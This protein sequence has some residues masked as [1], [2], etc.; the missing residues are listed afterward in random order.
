MGRAESSP[1]VP[2]G[3]VRKEG[4]ESVAG[5]AVIGRGEMVSN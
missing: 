4:T 5:S 2:T 1:S 3:A